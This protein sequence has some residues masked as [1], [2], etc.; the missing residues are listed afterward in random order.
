MPRE[1]EVREKEVDD[2]AAVAVT[3]TVTGFLPNELFELRLENRSKVVAYVSGRRSNDFLR[4]LPG[5]KVR[6]ELSSFDTG[7]GR[8]TQRY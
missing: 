4:L 1:K 8:I 7:R 6:V 3:A 2:E 5:D